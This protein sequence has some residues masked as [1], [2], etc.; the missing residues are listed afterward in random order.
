MDK[1]LNWSTVIPDVEGEFY[2]RDS[3]GGPTLYVFEIIDGVLM[4]G[5]K[6]RAFRWEPSIGHIKGAQFK[7]VDK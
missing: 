1:W 4:N 5:P 7:S 6:S 3:S 2:M